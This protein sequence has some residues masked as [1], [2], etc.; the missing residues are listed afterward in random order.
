MNIIGKR[1]IEYVQEG[2]KVYD[3]QGEKVGKVNL[4]YSGA[5]EYLPEGKAIALLEMDDEMLPDTVRQ[6]FH[7]SR[8]PSK[9]RERLY[10]M[11]FVKINTGLLAADRYALADQIESVGSDT[12]RLKVDKDDTLKF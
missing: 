7:P 8:V 12:I 1:L 4:V 6:L 3:R 11:G 2:M 9:L 10:Q 5:Y